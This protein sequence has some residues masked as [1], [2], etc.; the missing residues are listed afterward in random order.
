MPSYIQWK[1]T[2]EIDITNPPSVEAQCTFILYY[3]IGMY[4]DFRDVRFSTVEKEPIDYCL[5]SI[6]LNN[7]CRVWLK[8]PADVTKILIHYGNGAAVS[9]SNSN[10]VF[11][12][13]IDF[14][15]F[16]YTELT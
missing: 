1:Y 3:E 2:K 10:N 6:V 4:R 15:T 12:Y 16:D 8:L 13:F 9:E 11:D 14:V 7:N 5:E